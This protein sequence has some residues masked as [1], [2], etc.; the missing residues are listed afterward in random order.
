MDDRFLEWFRYEH[1]PENLQHTSK[2]FFVLADWLVQNITPGVQ[3]EV[4][5]QK[6]LEAKDAAVR[7]AIEQKL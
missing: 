1:L 4:A 5:L 7:A 3:R 6:L 2:Q